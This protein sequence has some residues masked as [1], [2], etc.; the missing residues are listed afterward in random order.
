MLARSALL[1]P[2]ILLVGMFTGTFTLLLASMGIGA[3]T[4]SDG[5]VAFGAMLGALPAGARV[6]GVIEVAR[7]DDRLPLPRVRKR[8]ALRGSRP[9]STRIL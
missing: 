6:Y 4:A 9:S 3:I 1:A 2:L 8:C 7:E 5:A